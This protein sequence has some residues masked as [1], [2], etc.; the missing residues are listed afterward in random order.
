MEKNK[1]FHVL[2]SEEK[3]TLINLLYEVYDL[4]SATDAFRIF[5]QYYEKSIPKKSFIT[6]T[7]SDINKFYDESYSGKYYAPFDMN[8]K[9]YSNIPEETELWFELLADYLMKSVKLNEMAEHGIAVQCFKKLYKLYDDM[10][11]EIVFA[12]EL[13]GCMLQ[14]SHKDIMPKYIESLALM[15]DSTDYAKEIV[16]LMEL[17][18]YD[19]NMKKVYNKAKL[20]GNKKQKEDLIKLVKE[21]EF[22]K[23]KMANIK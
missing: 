16:F 22:I 12:H 23:R 10:D 19:Y 15:S 1:V 13:D 9:N 2:K 7:L 8:S 3:K 5:S 20:M 17:D 6:K 21:N 18:E 11:E 4:L 14:A